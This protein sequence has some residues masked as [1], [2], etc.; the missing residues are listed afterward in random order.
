M[1]PVIGITDSN[2]F[3]GSHLSAALTSEGFRVLG[4]EL[5]ELLGA[6]SALKAFIKKS[7]IIIHTADIKRGEAEE[8]VGS[9]NATLHL[10][11]ALKGAK[12]K[13]LIFL[14]SIQADADTVYG[15]SKVLAEVLVRGY[16][17]KSNAQAVIVRLPNMFGEGKKPFYSSVVATFCYQIQ[18]GQILHVDAKSR[19]KSIHLMYIGDVVGQLM[20]FITAKSSTLFTF[21]TLTA[22]NRITVQELADLLSSFKVKGLRSKTKF[23]QEL[24]KTYL[25]YE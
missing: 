4:L 5:N 1:K 16:S 8:V 22:K 14:S 11:G 3:I 12:N 13:K 23:Y 9:V 15:K 20:R 18:H 21:T 6:G 24:Y 2:G 7:D 17:E 10:L 25:S 19:N